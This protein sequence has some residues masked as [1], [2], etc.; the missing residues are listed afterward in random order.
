MQALHSRA[1]ERVEGLPLRVDVLLVHL[2]RH[3][4]EPLALAE[5]DHLHL[6][7]MVQALAG[8]VARVDGHQRAHAL[9]AGASRLQLGLKQKP[10]ACQLSTY[11]HQPNTHLP[12]ARAASSW[13]WRAQHPTACHV[14]WSATQQHPSGRLDRNPIKQCLLNRNL[15]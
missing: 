9:A 8:G 7:I 2:V 3:Q 10:T 11:Q 5:F 15:T 12:L 14:S 13:A 4:H 1:P 6:I